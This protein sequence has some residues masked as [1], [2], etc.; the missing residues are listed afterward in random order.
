[1]PEKPL[2]TVVGLGGYSI[3]M[4]TA[5]FPEKGETVKA[6][7]CFTEPGGKGYNQAVACARLGART[8][9]IGSFG[10][11]LYGKECIDFLKKESIDTSHVKITGEKATAT[12]VILTDMYGD[13]R[14]TVYPGAAE[15]LRP[16]DILEA[17]EIISRSD[18][19]LIQLEVPFDTVKCAIETANKHNVR[20]ILNPAPAFLPEY[21]ILKKVYLLTPNEFE[22]TL[23]S[24]IKDGN[25][26]S[27]G[28]MAE[29][30]KASGAKNVIITL[31]EKGAYLSCPGYDTQIEPSKVAKVV[32]TTGAGDT[33]NAALAV[34]IA[35]GFD[36][37][38]AAQFATTAAA[39]SVAKKGVMNSI[40]YHDDVV[41]ARDQGD[42]SSGSL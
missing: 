4:S 39:L 20:V 16:E 41:K 37:I 22:A 25:S 7:N 6:R 9:F 23:I 31:G 38:K 21:D 3:F 29:K 40:P 1:M 15:L 35:K 5:T 30:L 14:V 18:V 19:L 42:G 32:D 8:A 12:G 36:M 13:N 26:I 34:Y 27:P 28:R 11:D 24:G 2:I 10:N 17:E 33:F